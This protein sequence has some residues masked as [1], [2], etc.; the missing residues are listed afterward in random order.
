VIGGFER[1]SVKLEGT[2]TIEFFKLI[3]GLPTRATR[4]KPCG[5][6][7]GSISRRTVDEHGAAEFLPA[8]RFRVG[9]NQAIDKR[10]PWR[11]S[12]LPDLRAPPS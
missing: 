4:R 1:G 3:L 6:A 11:C 10:P 2:D 9:R 12:S 7:S 8:R 5:P